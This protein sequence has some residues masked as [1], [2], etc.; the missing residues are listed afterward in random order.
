[1]FNK[2]K[3]TVKVHFLDFPEINDDKNVIYLEVNKNGK[4]YIIKD[5]FY[6][7]GG[8]EESNISMKYGNIIIDENKTF[9]EYNIQ[10]NSVVNFFVKNF[11][12]PIS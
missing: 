3:I 12:A 1:M 5:S 9:N 2:I 4:I 10:N 7:M 8:D 6:V 11:I